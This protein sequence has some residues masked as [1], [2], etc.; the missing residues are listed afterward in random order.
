MKLKKIYLSIT[1]LLIFYT[2]TY[3]QEETVELKIDYSNQNIADVI[4]LKDSTLL[5]ISQNIKKK[6]YYFTLLDNDFN[7]IF[8]D[9]IIFPTE[10]EYRQYTNDNDNIYVLFS[11]ANNKRK[12]IINIAVINKNHA[13][14]SKISVNINNNFIPSIIKIFNNNI[15]IGGKSYPSN[16]KI[17]L[18]NIS[19]VAVIPILTGFTN[20]VSSPVAYVINKDNN[21]VK[22]LSFIDYKEEGD[23][24][25][26]INKGDTIYILENIIKKRK[27]SGSQNIFLVNNKNLN[28]IN[29]II[30]RS[31]DNKIYKTSKILI[32]NDSIINIIGIYDKFRNT[33][34]INQFESTGLFFSTTD[35][36]SSNIVSSFI[37]LYDIKSAYHILEKNDSIKIL[38][39]K[40]KLQEKGK[41]IDVRTQFI[42]NNIIQEKDNYKIILEEFYP[43]YHT[44]NYIT[45]DYY[46]R[47]V[48]SSY[49]VFDG[50]RYIN[51]M[52]IQISKN[53]DLLWDCNLEMGEILTYNLFKQIEYI[54]DNN[55]N[56]LAYYA[57]GN[58]IS[59]FMED[60]KI[61][62]PKNY[63]KI[64]S[65]NELNKIQY[66]E[67]SGLA[68]WYGNFFII[69]SLMGQK[70]KIKQEDT[71]RILF[72][73]KIIFE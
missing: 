46:G 40:Q 19:S 61:L 16:L 56:I 11:N 60:D 30:G 7:Y 73:N 51:A 23:I 64:V 15:Y 71:K 57:N 14:Y 29:K 63:T 3:P 44:V 65:S 50:Y 1:L 54:K 27:H 31:Y 45:Y 22:Q 47:P 68:Q 37:N 13:K 43:E 4:T 58:I 9:S 21:S 34:I 28:L 66:E 17:F 38:K 10:M 42:L 52:L 6:K 5:L 20:I 24:Q 25:D 49:N 36:N 41:E 67:V 59:K 35:S 8:Y 62:K 69:Y 39:K 48:N 72:L 70:S 18:K 33:R 32:N 55:I 26:I 2:A 12:N 53:G